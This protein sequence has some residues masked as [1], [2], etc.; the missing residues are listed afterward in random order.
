[1]VSVWPWTLTKMSS[2]GRYLG[3]WVKLFSRTP[4]V[5]ELETPTDANGSTARETLNCIVTQEDLRW[6]MLATKCELTGTY[7]EYYVYYMYQIS[8]AVQVS[9]EATTYSRSPLL[10]DWERCVRQTDRDIYTKGQE[11]LCAKR[12]QVSELV[13]CTH[14]YDT[15][16][17]IRS[18]WLCAK[19][20]HTYLLAHY[21]WSGGFWIW[22]LAPKWSLS[23][24]THYGG[25]D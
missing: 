19:C 2:N 22:V 15:D 10:C 13:F 3:N 11:T 12:G 4:C 7:V 16:H 9:L 23:Y 1:M 14:A 5:E 8:C 17:A 25:E 18:R 21:E 20:A 24:F 6:L